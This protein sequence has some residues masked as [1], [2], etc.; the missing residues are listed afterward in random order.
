MIAGVVLSSNISSG[1]EGWDESMSEMGI[2]VN[3]N[4]VMSQQVVL[5]A[6][7]PGFLVGMSLCWC[8]S[9]IGTAKRGSVSR[10]ML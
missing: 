7:P 4:C 3:Y 2:Y 6:L 10:Q 5:K 8:C 1:P 9:L